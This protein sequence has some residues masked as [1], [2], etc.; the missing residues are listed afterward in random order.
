MPYM[1]GW[2]HCRAATEV[3]ALTV[4]PTVESRAANAVCTSAKNHACGL[5]A[6]L[7]DAA[8][9][10]QPAAEN[11]LYLPPAHMGQERMPMSFIRGDILHRFI[12][13]L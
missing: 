2:P 3:R 8:T 13:S 10:T 7:M 9:C 1:T 4:W 12:F 5:D 6:A 11:I